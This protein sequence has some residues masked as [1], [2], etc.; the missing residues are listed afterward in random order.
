MSEAIRVVE[1]AF[2]RLAYKQA[3]NQP[4]RR[5]RL[6]AGSVLHYMAAGDADYLGAKIYSTH[7]KHGARFLFLLYRSEDAQLLAIFEAN[8]LGR[9]RTGAA[10]GV[11]TRYMARQEA[12][13]LG[14]IGAGFQA[15]AQVEAIRAVRAL[16]QI[17]IWSRDQ[18]RL[19]RFAQECGATPAAAADEAVRGA[20]IVVTATSARDPVIEADW[21]APG[22]HLNAIGSNQ[23]A[24][25]ELPAP[26]VARAARIAIDSIEQGRMESGDLLLAGENAW[27][28]VV[29]L[30]EIVAGSVPGRTSPEEITLFKSNGLA[31]EDV[32]AA[33]FIY[34]QARGAAE[35]PAPSFLSPSE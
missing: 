15:R 8:H 6:P 17:K 7:P 33:A 2:R 5:L 22:T 23:A 34:E 32:A 4:R 12:C 27:T 26:L 30:Q 1:Q 19:R 3:I 28:N 9:I 35:R 24:R 21:V 16:E 31:I 25:R 10:S 20:H 29:E 11:A 18:E 13:T 14:V